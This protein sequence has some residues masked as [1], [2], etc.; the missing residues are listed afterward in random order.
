[1]NLH[2]DGDARDLKLQYKFARLWRKFV[3]SKG[4]GP[5]YTQN[6]HTEPADPSNGHSL[7]R[8]TFLPATTGFDD[9]HCL[10]SDQMKISGNC[11]KLLARSKRHISCHLSCR[12]LITVLWW[13]TKKRKL[14][15]LPKTFRR[16]S[17]L[18][19]WGTGKKSKHGL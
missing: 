5:D 10:R 13:R 8:M 1:M 15:I 18:C 14:N 3:R 17:W 19:M 6:N 11:S 7:S 16:A 2:M 12:N 4:S 9:V